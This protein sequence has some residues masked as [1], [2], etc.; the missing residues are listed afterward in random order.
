[1]AI[2]RDI[3]ER[4]AT[5]ETLREK[6]EELSSVL[7]FAAAG[8]VAS[9][10]AHELNQPLYAL[11]TYVQSCQ[12]LASRADGDRALLVELMDKAVREVA[13][14][15]EVV[16]RLREFFQTGATRLDAIPVARLL[17]AAAEG[18][19][20]RVER[21]QIGL[22]VRR[23]PDVGEIRCDALQI[24]MVLHNLLSNAVDAISGAG[25]ER[26]E[27]RL[28]ARAVDGQVELRVEDTGP[29]IAP[30][31]A[32]RLFEPFNTTK[33]EGMGL[34]LAIA[35]YIVE[36]HGGRL[37][38]EPLPGGSAFCVSLPVGSAVSE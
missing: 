19:R 35:R 4:R 32:L 37:W 11:A 17:E 24:E 12:I 22:R 1:V 28:E 9:S 25:G 7:R 13:R 31:V 34:G 18:I 36:A 29:G 5:E 14:A 21:H 6:Q 33:P 3:S 15:G 26:R 38:A 8:Q 27:V 20:R 30:E 10:L 2:L 16:R 23:D